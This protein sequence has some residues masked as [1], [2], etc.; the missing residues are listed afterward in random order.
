MV[1]ASPMGSIGSY[2]HDHPPIAVNAAISKESYFF[3]NVPWYWIYFYDAIAEVRDQFRL[4]MSVVLAGYLNST[5]RGMPY[6]S[7]DT[8]V[9]HY[10]LGDMLSHGHFLDPEDLAQQLWF[11][12]KNRTLSI[13]KFHVLHSGNLFFRSNQ[14]ELTVGMDL[15]SKFLAK[16]QNFFPLSEILLDSA[17]NPDEDWLK[18]VSAPM[19]F[20]SHGSYAISAAA[21]SIGERATPSMKNTNFPG[22]ETGIPSL[23]AKDWYLFSCKNF[24]PPSEK[25]QLET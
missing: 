5:G 8:C 1:A 12:S 3:K 14:N 19:L 13:A 11:W 2:L 17:G 7:L 23:L 21:L 9:V 4:S 20:T 10:R 22:C 15:M 25:S 18:M 16:L 6:F 24:V